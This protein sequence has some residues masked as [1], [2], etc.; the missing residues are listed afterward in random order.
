MMDD[1]NFI[2][3]WMMGLTMCAITIIVLFGGLYA[4][5]HPDSLIKAILISLL[6]IA[7]VIVLSLILTK[8]LNN[9]K[10]NQNGGPF[11]RAIYKYL[12]R[13]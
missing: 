6:S 1:N 2:D 5:I 7:V 4:A 9:H 10:D 12:A 8:R 3:T 11:V 13:E